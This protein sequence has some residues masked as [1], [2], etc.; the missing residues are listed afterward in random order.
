LLAITGCGVLDPADDAGVAV[1]DRWGPAFGGLHIFT[2]FASLAVGA[3]AFP[4][5]FAEEMLGVK[6]KALAV[7]GTTNTIVQAWCNAAMAQGTGT[8]ASLGPVGPNG[9]FDYGDYYWYKGTVGPTIRPRK[10]RAGG[11]PTPRP[12][13]I[14]ALS[15][16]A[17]ADKPWRLLFG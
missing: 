2:G 16:P 5:V 17:L 11:T 3:G 9:V 8:P 4:K 13:P 7:P 15:A 14:L 10:S 6:D 12:R 1:W